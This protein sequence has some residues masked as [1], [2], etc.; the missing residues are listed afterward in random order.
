MSSVDNETPSAARTCNACGEESAKLF[1]CSRCHFACYCSKECQTADWAV[2][3]KDS[4]LPVL[5]DKWGSLR[6]D[7]NKV[8]EL[9]EQCKGKTPEEADM[10][11]YNSFNDGE[12]GFEAMTFP[13]LFP[14]G[15][16]FYGARRNTLFHDYVRH[17]IRQASGQFLKSDTWVAY[18][19][20]VTTLIRAVRENAAPPGRHVEKLQQLKALKSFCETYPQKGFFFRYL[21]GDDEAY[22]LAY[23]FLRG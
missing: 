18:V 10:I 19:V 20:R 8:A 21:F 15:T 9:K 1:K 4:C 22:E 6:T 7:P 17:L 14:F 13:M 23:F 16:G 2:H 5:K 3:K 11:I 12:E